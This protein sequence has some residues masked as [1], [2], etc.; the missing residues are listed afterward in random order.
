MN[1][2]KAYSGLTD[3]EIA[4]MT[5]WFESHTIAQFGRYRQVEPTVVVEVAFD[6][7]MRSNRHRSGFALRF[8]RI[9]QLRTDKSAAEIDTLE[10]VERLYLGLQQGA[11]HLVTAGARK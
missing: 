11:E 5:R 1:I 9:V 4:E 10:T 6:V 7:I 8:P 3:A 2:G